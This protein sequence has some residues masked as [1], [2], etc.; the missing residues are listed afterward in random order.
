MTGT[1][2]N[3]LN[4]TNV[5]CGILASLVLGAGLFLA[6]LAYRRRAG[7]RSVALRAACVVTVALGLVL[8]ALTPFFVPVYRFLFITPEPTG[9]N[10]GPKFETLDEEL[11]YCD[12][13]VRFATETGLW[14]Y[15]SAQEFL[16]MLEQ[17]RAKRRSCVALGWVPAIPVSG[18]NS[19]VGRAPGAVLDPRYPEASV[20]PDSLFE[21]GVQPDA[22]G[23]VVDDH[24]NVIMPFCRTAGP[25][26]APAA[27]C[28]WIGSRRGVNGSV[29]GTPRRGRRRRSYPRVGPSFHR[30]VSLS[31]PLR[32]WFW[33]SRLLPSIT[34]ECPGARLRRPVVRATVSGAGSLAGPARG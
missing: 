5:V 15:S 16:A 14:R 26:T 31:P 6:W 12:D 21:L 22:G 10:F 13:T 4:D 28:I 7:R 24:S 9:L 33:W 29:I 20:V 3:F 1:I 30:H 19:C 8:F 34:V 17:V 23:Y 32:L 25:M 11:A 27:G 18:F 2:L